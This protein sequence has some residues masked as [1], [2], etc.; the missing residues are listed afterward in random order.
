[1][2][3]LHVNKVHES[4]VFAARLVIVL[5]LWSAVGVQVARSQEQ[6]GSF[7]YD[8]LRSK[9]RDLAAGEYRAD[10]LPPLPEALKKLS[11]DDYQ[12]IHFVPAQ[13]P[14]Q[15][16]NLK[17]SFQFF[18]RGFLYADPV[19]IHLLENRRAHDFTFSPKQFVY[20]TN[21]AVGN[22]PADLGFAGLRVL[23]PVNVGDK[24]DEAASFLGASYFRLVGAH[25]RY[26]A[27]AR[28]L[29]IN[30]AEPTGEEFPR[31]T[32]FWIEKPGPSDASLR[33]Y[34]LLD[35]PS[36]AGAYQFVI[37]PGEITRVEIDATVFLR[38]DVKK[39]GIAAL[40]SMFLT[41]ENRTR[42]LPDFRPE[43]HDSDGLLF[44]AEAPGWFWRPLINPDRE[45]V[46]TA[47]P[48]AKMNGFGL[49][50]R[51]RQFDH[52]QDL[53]AR[54]ELRPTL[55]VEPQGDWGAGTVELVEIPSPVE[56]NDNIVAYWVP[57]AKTGKGQE[58]HFVY[59]LS[60]SLAGPEKSRLLR[61]QSTRIAPAH[62][63]VP[64]RFVIDFIGENTNSLPADAKVETA[65]HASEGTIRN[66]VSEKNEVTGGWRAFFDLAEP[67]N[68]PVELRLFLHHGSELLSECWLYRYQ[69]P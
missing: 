55:W 28:G 33:L 37:A 14:W 17:F 8:S 30:T 65:V 44:S 53:V 42:L 13:A 11:Y 51:D 15:N 63:K 21:L 69:S 3:F 49:L 9:A 48:A 20:P 16:E 18:H 62:E 36:A 61:V 39:L 6:T 52:Y 22:W 34:A 32:E 29:A 26:G 25:Q 60:A 64:T 5:T 54:Y 40:T 50:Q 4:R 23:Y 1:M 7:S 68:K 31:F 38:K 45:H 12:A 59:R 67:G 2:R 27:S 10:T 43:V 24:Q 66:V 46:V 58:F 57:S 47:F 19:R 35:S 41:G 56:Y